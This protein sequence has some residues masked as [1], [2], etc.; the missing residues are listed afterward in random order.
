MIRAVIPSVDFEAL[1]IKGQTQ[2][3]DLLSHQLINLDYILAPLGLIIEFFNPFSVPPDVF[4]E[5]IACLHSPLVVCDLR[6]TQLP[7]HLQQPLLRINSPGIAKFPQEPD[8][9]MEV[10]AM[11]AEAGR[12]VR[13]L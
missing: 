6:L 13:V 9:Y 2:D 3:H 7:D 11:L 5:P 4:T 10:E 8:D 1:I 12:A